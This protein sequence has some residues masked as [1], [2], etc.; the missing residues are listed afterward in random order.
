[1][2]YPGRA[3]GI[4]RR[5]RGCSTAADLC[6]SEIM[7]G[8]SPS[9]RPRR[10]ILLAAGLGRRMRPITDRT[11]KPLV[12]IGGRTMLDRALDRL[13]EAG[14]VEAVVNVHHLADQ[15]KTHIQARAH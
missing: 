3:A 5:C 4:R 14:I 1:R 13:A 11:P 9:A 8:L 15:I 2:F 12:A 10:A 6:R 7:P